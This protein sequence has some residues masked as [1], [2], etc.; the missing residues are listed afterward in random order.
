MIINKSISQEKLTIVVGMLIILS[1]NFK[2]FKIFLFSLFSLDSLLIFAFLFTLFVGLV[3]A[4][5]LICYRNTIK[6]I[7]VIVLIISSLISYSIN[8]YDLLLGKIL[9]NQS[10]DLDL[11]N[12][13]SLIYLAFFGI[14]P[15]YLLIKINLTHLPFKNIL[16]SRAKLLF[17]FS[18]V[19]IALAL[20]ISKVASF[21][22]TKN[23]PV[24]VHSVNIG[25]VI[26]PLKNLLLQRD[27]EFKMTQ[28]KTT[29][30][31]P[32]CNLSKVNLKGKNLNSVDLRFA[33]LLGADLSNADLRNA[34]LDGVDLRQVNLDGAIL[35]FADFTNSKLDGIDLSNF[36][37]TGTV[38]NGVDFR[39]INLSN[40]NLSG[41]ILKNVNF[42]NLDLTGT[43]LSFSDLIGSNLDGVELNNK[44]LTGAS[45]NELDL[46]N[47]DLSNTI[48]NYANLSN[49]NLDGVRLNNQFLNGTVF[50]NV[51]FSNVDL[52]NKNLSGAI[53]KNANLSN[54]DLT[55]TILSYADLSGANLDGVDLSSKDLTG[56]ILKGVDLSDKD[57]TR[58]ILSYA[59]LSG[60]NLDGV[61]LSYKDLTGTILKGVDLSNKDLTRTI[62]SYADLSGANLDGTILSNTDLTNAILSE[63]DLIN[64]DL[65]DA[66][67]NNVRQIKIKINNA[68]LYEWPSIKEISNSNITRYDL[69]EN[70]EY[71]TTKKGLLY[72]FKDNI[73]KLVLDL[74]N[75]IKFPLFVNDGT[76]YGLLGVASNKDFVYI[77]YTNLDEDGTNSLIVD[78][79]SK[80]FKKVRNIL[81]I[82]GFKSVHFGGNL[83]FDS[84][85][86]LY[87]SVGD[88]SKD[89]EAQ[90]LNSLKG[91]ILRLDTSQAIKD[92]EIIAFGLR[93]PWGVTIDSRDRMFVL[94]CGAYDSEA[95]FLISDLNLDTPSNLG[96]PDYEGSLKKKTTSLTSDEV[97]RP[98]FEYRNRPGCATAGVYLEDIE[99]FLFADFFGTIRL[100]KQQENDLWYLLHQD[101]TQK[102]PIWGFG[103]DKKTK[104]IFIAPD[105]RELEI[106]FNQS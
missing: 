15:S 54:S 97:L 75:D 73:S 8:N 48:L 47:K 24:V 83:L 45:L 41:A 87:L 63:V 85:G 61:D 16:F 95:V 12:F 31:C 100:I 37:L 71:L 103:L 102:E 82:K 7:L 9:S 17:V 44:D 19:L 11:I 20:I 72:E 2:L 93:N 39:K 18:V 65:K 36:D 5:L 30:S 43:D 22:L 27:M 81:K 59:D 62:L 58:T 64:L 91:K 98:I 40:I 6:P 4:L 46:S 106:F 68:S 52:K 57:L 53:L 74:N 14:L 88:G 67:I 26:I 66:K 90:N 10:I 99:S 105:N 50:N 49:A 92:P 35:S 32:F 56:T 89:N 51:D 84:L 55:N 76:E 104:K 79:F 34:N 33:I 38:F 77:S 13:K 3:G 42:S 21:P 94:Q 96:W 80:D 23:N 70:I 78:E 28:I 29:N 60:A 1:I 86:K 69:S 101:D 25:K